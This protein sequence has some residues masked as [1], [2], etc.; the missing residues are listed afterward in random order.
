MKKKHYNREVISSYVCLIKISLKLIYKIFIWR[1]TK[2]KF[3]QLLR[4]AV[5]PTHTMSNGK[6]N[7]QFNIIGF[8]FKYPNKKCN[9]KK[10]S[11]LIN[12][13]AIM[14]IDI[15]STDHREW[16][17]GTRCINIGSVIYC[18]I[19]QTI[20]EYTLFERFMNIDALIYCLNMWV[21]LPKMIYECFKLYVHWCTCSVIYNMTME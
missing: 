3:I 6:M 2:K 12:F 5:P 10:W 19:L 16:H 1:D 7:I 20:I 8:L 13:G 4:L 9:D 15:V 17:N 11:L 14:S 21:M 18:A